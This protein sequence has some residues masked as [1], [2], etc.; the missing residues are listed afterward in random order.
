M[1]IG[2]YPPGGQ[3]GSN[4]G[5][6][7]SYAY[8]AEYLAPLNANHIPQPLN[9]TA[10]GAPAN[11]LMV[12]D[13]TYFIGGADVTATACGGPGGVNGE[14]GLA[15]PAQCTGNEYAYAVAQDPNM[16]HAWANL[17]NCDYSQTGKICPYTNGTTDNMIGQRHGGNVLNSVFADSHAKSLPY[18]KVVQPFGWWGY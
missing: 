10:I 16:P 12:T 13:A 9:S 5:A 17:G 6:E 15:D 8:N 4:F 1:V 2:Y 3:N 11:T 7:N 18:Q 14:S